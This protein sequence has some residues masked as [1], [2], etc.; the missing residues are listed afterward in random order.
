[1]E[2]RDTGFRLHLNLFDAIV[3]LC[4]LA[5]GA[6]LLWN[7]LKPE[8]VAGGLNPE[9]TAIRFTVQLQKVLPGTGALVREGDLLVDTVKNY[10]VGNVV[11]A[12]VV[13]SERT[14]LDEDA[15][16]YVTV[17]IPGYEDVNVVMESRATI[18]D[19]KI[20][21]GSGYELRVGERIYLRGPG[22]LASGEVFAIERGE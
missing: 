22:Y 9:T 15:R 12:S 6:Y 8:T 14:I 3:I 2:A 7:R 10:E 1:M 20:L 16:A 17:P 18:S 21:V 11:S 4:A 5:V 19:D 13:P